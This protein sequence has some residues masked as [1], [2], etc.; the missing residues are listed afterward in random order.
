MDEIAKELNKSPQSPKLDISNPP[1]DEKPAEMQRDL[2]IVPKFED[3]EITFENA[4]KNF[5]LQ[6]SANKIGP[7]GH[8]VKTHVSN[9]KKNS[10]RKIS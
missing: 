2:T 8:P 6:P 9:S 3:T 10:Y 4:P 5:K 7:I 1:S